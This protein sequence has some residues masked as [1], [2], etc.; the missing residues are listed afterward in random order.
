M[1]WNTFAKLCVDAGKS[2]N[3]V[4]AECG[5]KSS[6]TVTGWKNGAVPRAAVLRRISDYFD[7]AVEDLLGKESMQKEYDMLLTKKMNGEQV[8]DK[9]EEVRRDIIIANQLSADARYGKASLDNE[10]DFLP[11]TQA[12]HIATLYDLADE[13][14]RKVVD[15]MLQKYEAQMPKVVPVVAPKKP[16]EQPHR[17]MRRDGFEELDVY[18]QPS[19]AGFG[20]YLD[21]P[22]AQKQQYPAGI[23]PA[24][25]SFGILISGDSMEPKIH[26]RS[27]AFV[28]AVPAIDHGEIGIFVLNGQ[29]YCKQL[30]IDHQKREVRLHSFN[31]RYDDIVISEHDDLRTIGRVLG[32]YPE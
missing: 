11:S 24:A 7:I 19:A 2:P 22:V 17:K 3:T 23:V 26:N 14:D 15:L 16:K 32:N 9:L 25:T 20:N 29:S 21:V 8:D 12:M 6:G 31:N 10:D 4:A 30:V 13:R 5:V 28:Q 18:D 1:F 27:T